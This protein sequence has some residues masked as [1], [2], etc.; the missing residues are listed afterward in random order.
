MAQQANDVDIVE[1]PT[2]TQR[3]ISQP[4]LTDEYQAKDAA[5]RNNLSQAMLPPFKRIN[6]CLKRFEQRLVDYNL[7]GRGIQ[8]VGEDERISLTWISY[9]QVFLLWL[10]INL[11]ANNITLGMLGPAVYGLS[12]LDS[13]LCSI[14][15]AVVGSLAAAWL[16]TW[17]PVS[18]NRTLVST[19][20]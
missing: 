7:E 17:G 15:G 4:S 11:A 9:L 18:G 6:V 19:V 14:F 13:S 2:K 20:G 5:K 12:F 10:S 3:H 8:R 16:A 1:S